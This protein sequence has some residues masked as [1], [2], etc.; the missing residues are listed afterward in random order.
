MKIGKATLALAIVALMSPS[1]RSQSD[2]P[3]PLDIG[4]VVLTH[5]STGGPEGEEYYIQNNNDQKV[6]VAYFA[7]GSTDSQANWGFFEPHAK[8]LL[9]SI[10]HPVIVHYQVYPD[11]PSQECLREFYNSVSCN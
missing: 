8:H 4:S 11:I 2:C 3:Q 7:C 5:E 6:W 1:L 9:F 10:T